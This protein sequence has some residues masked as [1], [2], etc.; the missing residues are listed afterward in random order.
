MEEE[1]FIQ[2]ILPLR[3]EWEPVYSV[4]EP[5]SIGERVK[6][7]FAGKSYTGIVSKTD[8]NADGI[9]GKILRATPLPLP[10]VSEAELEFWREI[11]KYYLCSVGEVYK[12]AYPLE[13][14]ESEAA[15]ERATERLRERIALLEEKI[16]KARKEE[17]RG[18]YQG[19]LS[20]LKALLSGEV[21][22]GDTAPEI[23][24]SPA[25]KSALK[26]IEKGF[27]AGKTVLLHG[28]T[29]SGKTQLYLSLAR[30]CLK[31]GK[32]VLYLVPEIA[33]SR[34]L[35]ERVSQYIPNMA[36]YHSALPQGS[37][38]RTAQAVREGARL[39]LGTR[40]ALFLPFRELGL[41]IVDEEHDSSYK[42]SSPAPRYHA[43]ESAIMLGRIHGARVL[44][45]SATPS[46]ESLYN[47]INGRFVKVELKER[48]FKGEDPS[49]QIIDTRAE[50]RKKGMVDHL[51]I[52]L[53]ALIRETLDSG[54]QV[55]LLR[56]RRSWAPALQCGSCGYIPRCPR[57]NVSLSL[58]RNP[59][60]LL[61]HYC[62][63][64]EAYTGICPK[65]GEALQPLGAGTQRIEEE[66]VSAFPDARIGRLDSD[67]AQSEA[68][69]VKDFAQGKLDILVGTQMLTKGFDFPS[70]AMVGIIQADNILAQQDFRS[71]EKALQLLEQFRG[72]C[73][74]RG[75]QAVFVIQTREPGHPVF[76]AIGSDA[77]ARL[78]QERLRF[79]YPPLTRLIHIILHDSNEPRL[80]KMA[81]ELA[82]EMVSSGL[83]NPVGPYSPAP[84]RLGGE[85]LRQIRLMLPRDKK[86]AERKDCLAALVSAFEKSR[87][88]SGHIALDV[89]PA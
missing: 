47:S 18:R 3:L 78:L 22:P 79:G 21:P 8:V 83:P 60:R 36:V 6:V 29:G 76:G 33:L 50:W 37:R 28:V 43:R 66:L 10:P 86:L 77:P 17:T 61:C 32:S 26:G 34:Q 49:I 65:C 62:G 64:T 7:N 67:S 1:K 71:D 15:R 40:S 58:H 56:S 39:V 82:R 74:R 9:K 46:M 24:L 42:Q 87:K 53:L 5:V 55:L 63:H 45:G 68:S 51:S 84:D 72:R 20:R 14:T 30:E 23:V 89:D 27:D 80:E 13:K 48:Y 44:L 19:E 2:V 52:K 4:Q 12:A 35:Q 69:L 41:I 16:L 11:A 59:D 25:Q 57:C 54:K 75:Q 88:Y 70:L 31:K 73:G 81:R 85:Y 38:A